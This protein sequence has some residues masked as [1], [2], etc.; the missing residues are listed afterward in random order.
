MA[1]AK[2]INTV[3]VRLAKDHLGIAPIKAM[4]E[5]FGWSPT[6]G[7]KTMVLGTSGMT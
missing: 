1:M 6:R 5:S 7:H 4:A 2:S 3:P